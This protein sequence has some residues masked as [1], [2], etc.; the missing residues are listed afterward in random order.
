MAVINVSNELEILTKYRSLV[1]ASLDGES[2][3]IRTKETLMDL[4]ENRDFTSREKSEILSQVLGSLNSTVV[5][6][7]MG[8]AMQWASEEKSVELKKLELEKSLAIMEQ[9]ALLKELQRTATLRENVDRQAS[10]IRNYGTPTVV[11]GVVTALT[12]T[13]KVY[14]DTRLTVQQVT[15]AGKEGDILAVKEKEA[16]AMVHK[17]VADTY[18]NYGR[19][20]YTL[21]S[22]GLT[23]VTDI[24]PPTHT[25]L[26]DTQQSIAVQQA[27]GY[28]Y[29][30]WS[31]AVV[32]ASST[33]GT[34]MASEYPIFDPGE[35]GA[36]L[37]SS[38]LTAVDNLKNVATP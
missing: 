16:Q 24:T 2:V 38:V 33:L 30:A 1:K 6:T 12:D 13:G 21:D 18:V 5:S 20:T 23:S 28:A 15:N 34:A 11:D 17:I 8:T 31:S 10:T 37:L 7:A 9:D 36:Q 27:K 26:S 14:E 19:Y 35:P 22:T 4:F 25:T 29:N 32:G 3:Y